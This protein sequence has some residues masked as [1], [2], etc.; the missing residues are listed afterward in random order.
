MPNPLFDY[1][2]GQ[3]LKQEGMEAASSWPF[4]QPVGRARNIAI[5]LAKRHGEVT[6]DMVAPYLQER[7]PDVLEAIQPAAWGSIMRSPKL[8]FTGRIVES[9][10]LSRHCG[11][12]RV[13]AYNP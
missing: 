6:A 12:Q 1:A 13:W 11:T 10:K 5:M 8:R 3:K 7:L 2:K 4:D 9:K